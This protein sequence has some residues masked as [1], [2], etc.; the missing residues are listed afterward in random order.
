MGWDKFD[1]GNR[2]PLGP[3]GCIPIPDLEWI[4]KVVIFL[5]FAD[6]SS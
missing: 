2:F 4:G 5:C 3:F 6:P 1:V